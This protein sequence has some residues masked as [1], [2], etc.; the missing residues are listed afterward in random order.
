MSLK[1]LTCSCSALLSV[2]WLRPPLSL[3][4]RFLLL[5]PRCILTFYLSHLSLLSCLIA[6]DSR[7]TSFLFDRVIYHWQWVSTAWVGS[8]SQT[9]KDWHAPCCVIVKMKKERTLQKNVS[10]WLLSKLKIDIRWKTVVLDFDNFGLNQNHSYFTGMD[11]LTLLF[12]FSAFNWVLHCT[13]F[14]DLN[15]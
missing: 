2:R 15:L 11:E 4:V 7:G 8:L 9:S 13:Q 10:V 3:S 5:N 1:P 6:P 14:L 12:W